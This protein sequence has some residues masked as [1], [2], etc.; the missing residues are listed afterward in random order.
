LRH[1]AEGLPFPNLDDKF[2]WRAVG[3]HTGSV[4]GRAAETIVRVRAAPATAS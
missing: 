4:D 1:A 2:G 3:T